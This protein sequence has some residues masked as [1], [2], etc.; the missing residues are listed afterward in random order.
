MLVTKLVKL[1]NI[2]KL[3]IKMKTQEMP[4]NIEAENSLI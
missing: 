3:K 1:Y 4:N 2:L